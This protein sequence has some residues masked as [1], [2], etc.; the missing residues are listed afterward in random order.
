MH[1]FARN[2]IKPTGIV[3]FHLS[4]KAGLVLFWS[5]PQLETITSRP[6]EQIRF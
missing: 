2:S 1:S 4:F 5:I 3:A 6:T